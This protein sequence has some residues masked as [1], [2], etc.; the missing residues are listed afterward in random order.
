VALTFLRRLQLAWTLSKVETHL[1]RLLFLK[2]PKKH[3]VLRDVVFAGSMFAAGAVAAGVVCGR[4]AWSSDASAWNG[5]GA[6]AGSPRRH[7]PAPP[8]D[9]ERTGA[10]DGVG[11]A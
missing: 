5:D 9:R 4:R 2:K 8:P 3:H 10:G 7:T 6:P 11:G 1:Q